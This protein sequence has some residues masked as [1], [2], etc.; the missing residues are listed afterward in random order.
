[1]EQPIQSRTRTQLRQAIGYRLDCMISGTCSSTGD[2]ASLLDS[3]GLATF[4]DNEL[5]GR[6][7]YIPTLHAAGVA[8]GEKSWVSSFAAATDDATLA[9]VFTASTISGGAYE[10]WRVFTVGEIHSAIDAAIMEVTSEALQVKQTNVTITAKNQHE[11]NCLSGY[12]AL[13]QVEYCASTPTDE[14]LESCDSAW[15]ETS[16]VSGVTMTADTEYPHEGNACI[17]LVLAAPGATTLLASQ[18]IASTDLSKYDAIEVTVTTTSALAAGDLQI[19]LDNTAACASAVETLSIPATTALQRTRHVISLA[20]P[21]SDTAIISI[22]VYLVTDGSYT[23][24]IDDIRAVSSKSKV[25]CKLPWDMWSIV[26]NGTPYL[27]LSREGYSLVGSNTLLRLTGLAIPAL[28][29][30]DTSTTEVDPYWIIL[31]VCADLLLN[32]SKAARLSLEDREAKGKLYLSQATM[33]KPRLRTQIPSNVRW[34]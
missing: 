26:S 31:R 7:V 12:E 20:N 28:L 29:T 23:I 4:G 10:M 33:M 6:Q 9:P 17:K 13:T 22:G 8:A 15:T 18:A 1:M 24:Y 19:K 34:V 25:Y 21:Q 16:G 5:N 11:Y 2:S 14:Q 3:Y 27:K 30:A 32:H